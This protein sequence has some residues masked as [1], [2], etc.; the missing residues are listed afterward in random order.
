MRSIMSRASVILILLLIGIAAGVKAVSAAENPEEFY[1]GKTLNWIVASE[2]GSPTDLIARTVAPFLA[3]ETGAR[4]KVEDMKTDEGINFVYNKGSRDGLTIGSKTTDA[5]IGNEILKAPGVQYDTDKFNFVADLYPSVKVF[6][7]SPKLTLKTLEALRRAK[8]LRAGGTS[9]KG[10][11]AM[12]SAVMLEIL[13]LDGKVITGYQ[14]KKNLTLAMARGEVDCMV[15]SDDT[16]LRDEKD[17]YILN[18]MT[19]G[20]RKSAAVPQVPTPA[21]LGVKISKDLDSVHKFITSGGIAVVLPPGVP[22]ERVEY[23]RKVFQGLSNNKELQK[24]ME[25]LTGASKSFVPGR[26]LQQE[27]VEIKADKELAGK[28]DAIFKK[29]TAVR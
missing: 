16:A 20:D 13:G 17:G 18:F 28:L 14:G 12:S 25:R 24:A 27:M 10:S 22:T 26:E 2:P 3:K 5:I 21:E 29:Y 11:I 4:L 7:L 9:A 1:R 15:T 6:Q 23:L 19:V 8:G